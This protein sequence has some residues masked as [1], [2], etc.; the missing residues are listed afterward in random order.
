ML[1]KVAIFNCYDRLKIAKEEFLPE[2][3]NVHRNY[4]DNNKHY[5]FYKYFIYKYENKNCR[6]QLKYLKK[7]VVDVVLPED[8]MLMKILFYEINNLAKKTSN[9]Q[10]LQEFVEKMGIID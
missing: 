5:V 2:V 3:F 8:T 9:Y 6:E 7:Y 4:D 1:S 10:I